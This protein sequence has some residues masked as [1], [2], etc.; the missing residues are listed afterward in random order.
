MGGAIFASNVQ[1]L[2]V[3]NCNFTWNAAQGGLATARSTLGG[4]MLRC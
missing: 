2:T 1:M 4:L 3:N